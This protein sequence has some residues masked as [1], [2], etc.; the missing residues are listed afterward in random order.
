MAMTTA[1]TDAPLACQKALFS[2]DPDECWLDSAYMGPLP[3][4]VRDAGMAALAR[5]AFPVGITAGDFFAPAER[6]RAMLARLVGADPERIAFVTTATSGFALL[7]KNLRPEPGANVVLLGDQFPSNVYAWRRWR[8]R[9]VELRMVVAPDAPLRAIAGEPGRTARWNDAVVEAIDARTRLV[10]IEQAHWT[11]G[12]LFDLARIGARCRQVGAV[13]AVDATQTAGAMPIDVDALGIDALVVHCYKS[14]LASYGLGFVVL[15]ERFADGEPLDEGWLVRAGSDDFAGL[16][17]Y[18]D[19][20]AAGMRRYD[21]SLRSN[22]MLIDMLDA[23]CELLLQ[24]RPERIRAYLLDIEAGFAERL[25]ASGYEIAAPADRAANLFGVRLPSGMA[26]G[27]V[28]EALAA[29]RIR[30]SVR[31]SAVRVAPHVFN[32]EADLDRLAAALE[33]LAA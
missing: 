24:W 21:T 8:A 9:D 31:G 22:G 11:D 1:S 28:R 17:D 3:D 7:E 5:R 30:V 33:S 14:M 16:V 12:T 19:A 23:A 2:L 26:P 20:Y 32:D 6:V 4:R 10:S 13:F 15:S 27:E 29:R 25:A 18:Q